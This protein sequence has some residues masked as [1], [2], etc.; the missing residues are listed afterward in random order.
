MIVALA[1]RMQ[2]QV[3]R[4]EQLEV[5]HTEAERINATNR[6]LQQVTPKVAQVVSCL[7]LVQARLA[8][9]D[10]QAIDAHLREISR[11]LSESRASFATLRQQTIAL[12][13]IEAAIDAELSTILAAWTRASERTAGPLVEV[14]AP[15]EHLPELQAKKV[16]LQQ[17][18]H[19]LRDRTS[20]LPANQADLDQFDTDVQHLRDSLT[21]V[22]GL[23][24]EVVSFLRKVIAGTA[25]L[26]DLTDLVISWCRRGEHARVFKVSF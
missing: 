5:A 19:A 13:K 21:S 9:D 17:L 10:Q 2:Q 12:N 8:T 22:E 1:E 25:T 6:A 4:L 18:K 11:R 26:A 24:E 20:R 3:V 14:L 15:L 16:E 23:S 7:E